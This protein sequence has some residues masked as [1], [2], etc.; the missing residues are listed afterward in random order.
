MAIKGASV[1]HMVALCICITAFVMNFVCVFIPNW[2]HGL[3][4]GRDVYFGVWQFCEVQLG[5]GNR[6]ACKSLLNISV[7]VLFSSDWI[8]AVQAMMAMGVITSLVGVILHLL[9]ITKATCKTRPVAICGC[10]ANLATGVFSLIGIS[11][12][13][14]EMKQGHN[15]YGYQWYSPAFYFEWVAILFYVIGVIL[16]IICLRKRESPA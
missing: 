14:A 11:I 15:F 4:V 13:A 5:I 8:Q 2:M 16:D 12:Y 6:Y 7:G 10:A 3:V 9:Y 1:V